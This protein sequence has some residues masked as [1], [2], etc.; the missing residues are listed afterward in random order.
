MIRNAVMGRLRDELVGDAGANERLDV[1]VA[2]I[3]A[4]QLPGLLAMT[5]GRDLG[6]RAGGWSFAIVN[7]WVDAAAYAAYDVEAEHN[8]HRAVIGELCAQIARVQFEIG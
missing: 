6:L 5:C 7:D 4:L 3:A 8:R 1:A 2:A